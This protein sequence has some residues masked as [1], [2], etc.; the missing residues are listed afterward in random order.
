V[1]IRIP[2]FFSA[3]GSVTIHYIHCYCTVQKKIKGVLLLAP[4]QL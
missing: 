3:I 4:L 1:G 2:S